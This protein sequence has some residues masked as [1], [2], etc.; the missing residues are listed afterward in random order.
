MIGYRC[1]V[2]GVEVR[3]GEGCI[4]VDL[5]ELSQAHSAFNAYKRGRL[6]TFDESWRRPT[7]NGRPTVAEWHAW[8]Y[9]HVPALG[10]QL[11]VAEARTPI[12][13]LALVASLWGDRLTVEV[14]DLGVFA[15]RAVTD[16]RL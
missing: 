11:D 7:W 3:D 8:C 14:T 6:I 16:S 15:H 9:E 1:H 13:L 5:D 12:Q 2:C 4:G 10:N